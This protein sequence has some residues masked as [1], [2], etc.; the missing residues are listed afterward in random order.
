MP[1]VVLHFPFV[2]DYV[3]QLHLRAAVVAATLG[4]VNYYV[5][6]SDLVA[7]VVLV[8][9]EFSVGER[10][11]VVSEMLWGWGGSS[12]NIL[13]ISFWGIFRMKLQTKEK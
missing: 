4:P 11:G 3:L 7:L 2:V 9:E 6:F 1:R 12:R 5:G 8:A 13:R 10:S